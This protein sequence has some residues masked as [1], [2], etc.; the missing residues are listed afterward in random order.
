[1]ALR[2]MQI[3]SLR[4]EDR[5]LA[6]HPRNVHL[7]VAKILFPPPNAQ[8]VPFCSF[9][10]FRGSDLLERHLSFPTPEP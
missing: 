2:L 1:M 3:V 7:T 5:L 8:E 6:A 4:I 10:I 9:G